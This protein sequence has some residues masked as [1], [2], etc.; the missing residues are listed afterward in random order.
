MSGQRGSYPFE[1]NKRRGGERWTRRMNDPLSFCSNVTVTEVDPQG[2][3][4]EA[5]GVDPTLDTWQ[6]RNPSD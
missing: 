5:R 3:W 4:N 1:K 6:D 2:R